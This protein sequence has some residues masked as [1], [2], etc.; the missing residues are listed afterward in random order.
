M[1]ELPG[2]RRQNT[3]KGSLMDER[4]RQG[5]SRGVRRTFGRAGRKGLP[6]EL[7]GGGGGR[8]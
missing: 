7:A 5:H 4:E 2:R 3:D 6:V 8:M 1:G